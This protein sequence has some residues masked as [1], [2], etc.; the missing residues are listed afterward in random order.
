MPPVAV[1]YG[2]KQHWVILSFFLALLL[3]ALAVIDFFAGYGGG[4]PPSW[5]VSILFLHIASF[6]ICIL[7]YIYANEAYRT[8][9]ATLALI[10]IAIS[11]GGFVLRI[12]YEIVFLP[13]HPVRY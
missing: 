3:L 2:P 11:L 4:I 8:V 12:V 1:V 13:F 10:T 7:G 5:R 6:Y 9:E